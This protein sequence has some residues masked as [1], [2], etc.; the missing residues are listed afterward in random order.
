MSGLVPLTAPVV[1]VTEG[2]SGTVASTTATFKFSGSGF[3]GGPLTT[4]CSLDGSPF[5][6]CASPKTYSGLAGAH[7]FR[8]RGTDNIGNTATGSRSWTVEAS[9]GGGGRD[10]NRRASD[11]EPDPDRDP[12]PEPDPH[13]ATNQARV[14]YL[15]ITGSV[16]IAL[17]AK[18][19]RAVQRIRFE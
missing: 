16:S 6:A 11:L 14:L 3:S 1:T 4:E 18:L 12:E 13:N 8:V 7:E 9:P 2:P 19:I 17:I 10:R 5:A 15:H